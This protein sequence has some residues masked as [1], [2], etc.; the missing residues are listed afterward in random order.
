MKTNSKEI[1]EHLDQSLS[2]TFPNFIKR[3]RIVSE[4]EKYK[5]KEDE[6]VWRQQKGLSVMAYEAYMDGEFLC[7]FNEDEGK[8]EVYIKVLEGIKKGIQEGRLYVN[9]E[10]YAIKEA[11][12]DKKNRLANTVVLEKATTPEEKI[13]N[14]T[15]R[16]NA[17]AKN[18]IIVEK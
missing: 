2:G 3:A 1:L 8:T 15:I 9:P 7:F 4:T 11:E 13:M 6:S 5:Y 18:K 14:A 10:M 16:K 12:Q 17:K